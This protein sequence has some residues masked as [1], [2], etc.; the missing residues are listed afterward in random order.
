[1]VWG[2]GGGVGSLDRGHNTEG[3]NIGTA[4]KRQRRPGEDPTPSES[5]QPS[6]Y[7]RSEVQA[8]AP[9]GMARKRAANRELSR[10]YA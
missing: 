3:K 7:H 5:H 2:G 8:T 1:M 10:G 6:I 9:R 4:F